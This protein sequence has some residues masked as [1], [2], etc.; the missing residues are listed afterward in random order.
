MRK[1]KFL[2][3]S[4]YTEAD[5]EYYETDEFEFAGVTPIMYD[6]T[7]FDAVKCM[8]YRNRE[9]GSIIK[10]NVIDEHHPL[11]NYNESI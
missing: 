5:V 2:S 8:L 11:W 3:K 9:T 4:K 1:F 10:G 6:P 7:T